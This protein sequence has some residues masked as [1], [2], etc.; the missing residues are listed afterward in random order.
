MKLVL[1]LII[2]LILMCFNYKCIETFYQQQQQQQQQQEQGLPKEVKTLIN[3]HL[4]NLKS[5][6]DYEDKIQ[7]EK[8][9]SKVK[10]EAKNIIGLNLEE[11]LKELM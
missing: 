3:S 11:S 9:V 1:V 8:L 6:D 10:K 7:I 5:K 2:F 4:E